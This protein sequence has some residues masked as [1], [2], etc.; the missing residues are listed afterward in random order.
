MASQKWIVLFAFLAL[1]TFEVEVRSSSCLYRVV[2]EFKETITVVE[3][4]SCIGKSPNCPVKVNR[5]R[6]LLTIYMG[7]L[8][9]P[10]GK[11]NGSHPSVWEALESMGCD[12]R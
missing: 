3:N 5:R 9:I 11:S 8:E 1:F 10:V 2:Q 4:C 7:R 12:L 6:G